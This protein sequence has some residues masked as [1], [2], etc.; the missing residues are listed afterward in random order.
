MEGVKE[1]TLRNHPEVYMFGNCQNAMIA[2]YFLL[3]R[4]VS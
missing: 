1:Y 4:N 2:S 3:F